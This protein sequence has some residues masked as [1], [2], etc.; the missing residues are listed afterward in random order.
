M[1]LKYA[2]ALVSLPMTMTVVHG[3]LVVSILNTGTGTGK[4]DFN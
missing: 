1:N 4:V 2:L 3:E